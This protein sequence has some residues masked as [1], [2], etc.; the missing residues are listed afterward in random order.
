MTDAATKRLL[1]LAGI[2][3]SAMNLVDSAADITRAQFEAAEQIADE[4]GIDASDY[5]TITEIAKVIAINLGTLDL[6]SQR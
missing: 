1:H 2:K 6:A 5:G 3:S 4:L